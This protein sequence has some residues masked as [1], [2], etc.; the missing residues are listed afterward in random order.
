[1]KQKQANGYGLYDMSGNVYEWCWDWY[2][3]SQYTDDN[4][5][6]TNPQGAGL[7]NAYRVR[8]GG[9]WRGDAGPCL[10]SRRGMYEPHH[11]LNDVGFRLVRSAR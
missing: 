2:N 11:R 7:G 5:G 4:A 8:R 6:V 1:M 10:V 9:G 3:N